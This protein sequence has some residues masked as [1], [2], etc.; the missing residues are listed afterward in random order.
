MAL[1][2]PFLKKLST[3]K[4]LIQRKAL[5]FFCELQHFHIIPIKLLVILRKENNELDF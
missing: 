4:Y 1:E 2:F 5:N 3:Y